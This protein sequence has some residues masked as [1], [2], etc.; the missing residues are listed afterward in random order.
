M[1]NAGSWT[2]D[3]VFFLFF[4]C[5]YS[6]VLL[7]GT[8]TLS[9]IWV[10]LQNI[11][12]FLDTMFSEVSDVENVNV[13]LL[14]PFLNWFK[15]TTFPLL[16]YSLKYFDSKSKN[17]SWKCEKYPITKVFY[18]S[19]YTNHVTSQS[20]YIQSYICQ[21]GLLTTVLSHEIVTCMSTCIYV[22]SHYWLTLIYSPKNSVFYWDPM[23]I[24]NKS[25][26]SERWT[27]TVRVIIVL[28]WPC[29]NF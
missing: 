13:P 9:S 27:H 1:S 17:D 16:Y 10:M 29:F 7:F 18:K 4:L 19:M 21:S 28:Q 5:M 6:L 2:E 8:K 3:S 22:K 25:L 15:R 24:A 11:G 12:L 20:N 26:S 14:K 23:S